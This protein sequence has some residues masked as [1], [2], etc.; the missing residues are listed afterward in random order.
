MLRT[1]L[2]LTVITTGIFACSKVDNYDPPNGGIRGK[3]KDKITG[4]NLESQQPNGFTVQLFETGGSKNVPI[5]IPGKPDG[6]FENSFIFQNEYRVVPTQG[7]FFPVDTLKIQVGAST[8]TNF[9]VM[10]FLALTNVSVTPSSGKI[11]ANY[12][13][14]RS[15][16]GDKIAERQTLVSTIP[17]VNNIVFDF[18][19][20]TG[21]SG[22]PDADILSSSYKD[23]ITGLISGK[24]YYV[25]IATRTDNALRKYNYSKVFQVTI[26]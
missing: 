25:R 9:E 2:F 17:T 26:P 21:L 20:V 10:P 13:I 18:R 4:E 1:I 5:L 6:T 24:T 3:L 22:L 12:K 19:T 14:A 16:V 8:E 15:Q 23:E 7:A 11:T